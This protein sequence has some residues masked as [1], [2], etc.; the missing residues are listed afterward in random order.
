MTQATKPQA[1]PAPVSEAVTRRLDKLEVS[2]GAVERLD[3]D[4]RTSSATANEVRDQVN[5]IKNTLEETVQRSGEKVLRDVKNNI[6]MIE[7]EL[8]KTATTTNNF[9]TNLDDISRKIERMRK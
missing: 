6:G 3:R 5:R 7:K 2:L 1:G 9:K 4:V 8:A